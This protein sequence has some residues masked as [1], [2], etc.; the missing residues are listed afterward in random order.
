MLPPN[1]PR[2]QPFAGR[3]R[4]PRLPP[5]PPP[6]HTLRTGSG[7]GGQELAARYP[8][9]T[10]LLKL[11]S[12]WATW[13]GKWTPYFCRLFGGFDGAY[14]EV[15][16]ANADAALL[17]RLSEQAPPLDE[18]HKNNNEAAKAGEGSGG[19]GGGTV[20]ASRSRSSEVS[21]AASSSSS[22]SLARP[23]NTS[24]FLSILQFWR[25]SSHRPQSVPVPLTRPLPPPLYTFRVSQ[26][27]QPRRYASK[28]HAFV[29]QILFPVF[30]LLWK[31]FCCIPDALRCCTGM[32]PS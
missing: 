21:S 16:P 7:A 10:G 13:N 11:R 26:V 4:R 12:R 17:S 29:F 27:Y 20:A 2:G 22:S 6:P 9:K 25:D 31:T 1:P 15:Y 19:G 24:S 23:S 18:D 32:V 30:V 8:V 5:P 3:L 14:V 28:W